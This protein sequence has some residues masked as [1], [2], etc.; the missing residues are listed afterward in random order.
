MRDSEVKNVAMSREK[1]TEKAG[2]FIPEA[3]ETERRDGKSRSTI[4]ITVYRRGAAK[5]IRLNIK[6][7]D[8]FIILLHRL[9]TAVT[10]V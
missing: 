4:K 5:V 1:L 9:I 10:P 8:H 6:L 7:F 3:V 2:N